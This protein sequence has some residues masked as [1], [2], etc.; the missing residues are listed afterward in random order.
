MSENTRFKTR[1][2]LAKNT[3]VP[4]DPEDTAP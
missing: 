3:A 4:S 1:H 2:T